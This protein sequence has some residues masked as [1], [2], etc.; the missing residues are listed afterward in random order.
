VSGGNMEKIFLID[1][2]SILFRAFYA[3]RNLST[4]S[5]KKTNAIYGTIKMAEKILSENNVKYSA[6]IFDMKGPTFR[7]K[8]YEQYKSN[9]EETPSD[10]VEQIEP[11]KEILRAMGLKVL[12]KEGYEAD[13]IIAT[14]AE[15]A[16]KEGYE[17]VIVTADKDLF[18]LVDDRVKIIHTK[19]ENAIL[20]REGVKELFGVYPES[21]TDV[22]ALWGDP[23]DNIKGVPKIGEKGAK[24]LILKFGSLDNLIANID[25][26]EKKVYRE[27]LKENIDSALESKK[28]ATVLRDV[29]IEFEIKD[30]E[31]GNRDEDKLKALFEKY[32]FYSLLG[33]KKGS[34]EEKFEFKKFSDEV[35]ETL[36]S[37][38]NVGFSYDER[39]I[40]LSDGNNIFVV[41][42]NPLLI[43]GILSLNLVTFDL[44]KVI[45]EFKSYDVKSFDDLQLTSYLLN[46]EDPKFLDNFYQNAFQATLSDDVKIKSGQYAKVIKPLLEKIEEFDMTKLYKEI[47]LKVAP[48]LCRMEERGI[49]VDVEY[50]KTLSG[51]FEKMISSLEEK[52]FK[53]AGENFNISSPKQVSTILFEKMKLP[54]TK[55]TVKT[56]SYSTDNEALEDIYDVHP[57]IP[58]ILEHRTLNK[59]KSTYI[60]ALPN[61]INQKTGRIH[62]T[63]N[64]TG[65]ATGRLSSSEPNLQNIP[66]KGEYGSKIRRAFIADKGM[67]FVSADYSQ[68]ELRILAHLSGDEKLINAFEEGMDIHNV[69]ASQIFGVSENEVSDEMR[70]RAKIVNYSIIYGKTVYGLSKD[71]RIPQK[72]AKEFIERYFSSFPKIHDYLD[73]VKKEAIEKEEV[74]TIL[75]RRRFFKGIKNGGKQ[76]LDANLRQAVNATIQGS[77][78]DLI[79]KAM[80]DVYNNLPEDAYILLQIHD[81][82]LIETKEEKCEEVKEI[83]KNCMEN[84]IPLKAKIE[85]SVNSAK[86]WDLI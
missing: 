41:E 67:T 72:E 11:T 35:F 68:I 4:R 49:V 10:L 81:E 57:I 37:L 75:G 66:I 54:S 51:D 29:P 24:E 17:V 62:T 58:L 33:E 65:T 40:Y 55:K 70:R 44:K 82:L 48:I 47:E 71:L 36:I 26:I 76:N 6:F 12:E 80:I 2:T 1:A 63:F 18:Q 7:H 13:D 14:I 21:V 3:V 61:Y 83:L 39:D 79:K 60:D 84:A 53:E 16:K 15:R 50:L 25:K 74:K 19:K 8:E 31:I 5:G 56:K 22:L 59:L 42:R 20:D 30:F 64:Q 69:T 45:K 43:D 34:I 9:R 38:K 28:L 77:A 78:A 85:V 46:P 86:S 32:E 27:S 73:L 52:I 23:V